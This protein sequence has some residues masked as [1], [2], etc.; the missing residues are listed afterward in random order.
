MPRLVA[1]LTRRA[2]VLVGCECECLIMTEAGPGSGAANQ[3]SGV[4]DHGRRVVIGEAM[5]RLLLRPES[6]SVAAL[7]ILFCI[8][9]ALS[10][11]LFP[12]KLTYISITSF[13]AELGIVSIGVTLLMIGGHF[14]LSVGAVLGLTSYVATELMRAAGWTPILAAPA[15]PHRPCHANAEAR[16][17]QAPAFWNRA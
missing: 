8:L 4:A 10:P 17:D 1:L 2:L 9:T 7:V 12:T 6:T 15:S 16:S 14:D 13:A 11:E 3:M 5:R